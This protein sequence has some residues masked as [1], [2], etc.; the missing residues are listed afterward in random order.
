MQNLLDGT[1][2]DRVDGG[3]NTEIEIDIGGGKTPTSVITRRSAAAL[4]LRTGEAVSALF[5]AAHV[6]LDVD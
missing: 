1:V 5:D 2:L 4:A 6:I 3:A